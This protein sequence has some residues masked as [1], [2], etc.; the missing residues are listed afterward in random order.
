MTVRL[1]L[2]REIL[3]RVSGDWTIARNLRFR[4]F[5]HE[6]ESSWHWKLPLG[7]NERELAM[8]K[9]NDTNKQTIKNT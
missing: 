3:D 2:I 8:K 4:I 9:K 6:T 7:A 1:I 5:P